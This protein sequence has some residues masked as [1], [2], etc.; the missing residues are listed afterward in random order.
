[1]TTPENDMSYA[2]LL[3]AFQSRLGDLEREGTDLDELATKLDEGFALLER[4]KAKLS[5]TEAR[6]DAI[7]RVRHGE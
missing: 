6:I 3:R 5:A 7:V 2:D 1:M 4:L